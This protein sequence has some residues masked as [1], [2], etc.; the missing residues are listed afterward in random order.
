MNDITHKHLFI[1]MIIIGIITI[2][3]LLSG[4]RTAP[5]SMSYNPGSALQANV[6][7]GTDP[8]YYGQNNNFRINTLGRQYTSYVPVLTTNYGNSVTTTTSTPSQNTYE[9]TYTTEYQQDYYNNYVI[10]G[11]ENPTNNYSILTG[12]P[13]R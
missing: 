8:Y 11:C 2:A 7:S 1:T 3:L 5:Y 6:Y 12:E 13:C 4:Y 9:Y 10:P